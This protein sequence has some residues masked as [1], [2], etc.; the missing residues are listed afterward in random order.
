MTLLSKI[1]LSK[2]TVI[3][4]VIIPFFTCTTCKRSPDET[5]EIEKWTSTDPL[6]VNFR[7]R[8]NK[9]IAGNLLVNPSFEQTKK[10]LNISDNKPATIDGWEIIGKDVKWINLEEKVQNDK[11][12]IT[13]SGSRSVCVKRNRADETESMGQGVL[14]DYIKVIPGNYRLSLF[15]NLK[16]IKNPKSRL[17][18]RIFDAVDIRIL[19][20]DRNKLQ[21]NGE[22]YSAHYG[23]IFNCGFKGVSF[24]NFETIDSSG[25]LHINGYSHIFPFADGDIPDETKF[26]KVFIGLKGTGTIWIDD[27]SYI[28]TNQNLTVSERLADLFDST[29]AKA[30]LLIP[31]PKKIKL[32]ESE[33]YF[34]KELPQKHPYI[35]IP[36]N[37][38]KDMIE[39]A[40]LLENKIKDL[41]TVIGGFDGKKSPTFLLKPS[42]DLPSDCSILFSLGET[43]YFK[44]Y[45][46]ELPINKIIDKEQGYIIYTI[47]SIS[48][49]VFIYGNSAAGYYYGMQTLLQLFDNKSNLFHNA[50]IIDYPDEIFRSLLIPGNDTLNTIRFTDNIRFNRIYTSA[51]TG[52]NNIL[53][54]NLN[55]PIQKYGFVS[56]KD[57][58]KP[59]MA[60]INAA[61]KFS[62]KC[63]KGLAFLFGNMLSEDI[64]INQA[65]KNY[66]C[67]TSDVA[68]NSNI[69]LQNISRFT[70]NHY[71]IEVLVPDNYFAAKQPNNNSFKYLWA[72]RG[73]QTWQMDESIIFGLNNFNGIN[74]GFIDFSLYPKSKAY[75]YFGNDRLSPYKNLTSCL[76]EPYGNEIVSEVYS[77]TGNLI[78]VYSNSTILDKI[79]LITASDFYWN[80]NNYNPDFALFKAL[81]YEFG[82]DCARDVLK[83]NDLYF[84]SRSELTL[85]ADKKYF[86]KNVRKAYQ[87]ITELNKVANRLKTKYSNSS[88]LNE[89]NSIFAVLISELEQMKKSLGYTPML[90]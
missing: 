61:V 17:G 12:S 43:D 38:N 50:N 19:Y 30:K 57:N 52:C 20:Y 75:D 9:Y 82:I 68:E 64:T 22:Q 74:P 86:H 48:D 27:V 77:K 36:A 85:A 4:L 70:E 66:Y 3:L 14:S 28:Y 56:I 15:L 40:H 84:E 73:L 71:E 78:L 49:I 37:A 53:N 39:L 60:Q 1:N 47:P 65:L 35:L 34:K 11:I 13:H 80:R 16:D 62:G 54:D 6:A 25:W 88:S 8:H 59:D 69:L 45:K 87:S 83:F 81:V 7:A 33:V 76:F 58:E 23:Q 51:P 42:K 2:L 90:Q 46:E 67:H 21:I 29:F 26:V 55:V 44:K 32:L 41:L 63:F 18:T 79:R 24:S 10:K 5:E 89:L 72:G 31:Q